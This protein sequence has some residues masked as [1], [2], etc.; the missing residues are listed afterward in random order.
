MKIKNLL[1]IIFVLLVV[2]ISAYSL[3]KSI[4][5]TDDISLDEIE[6]CKTTYWDEDIDVYDTCTGQR[7]MNICA[8]EP[9]NTTCSIQSVS[10]NYTCL[11]GKET[12]QKSKEICKDNEIQ[13]GVDKLI[14]TDEY[15]IE[16]GQWGKCSYT[17][18]GEA[19]VITCDSRFDGDNNGICT[20]GESCTQFRITKDNVQTLVKNSRDDFVA[21]DDTFFLDELEL[22]VVK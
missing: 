14:G 5:V 19:L 8:D 9:S 10:Y 12:V 2:S 20:S 3:K 4:Q 15:K 11:T 13:I 22:E 6:D 1:I 21:N 16:Y 7:N 18:E 17:T